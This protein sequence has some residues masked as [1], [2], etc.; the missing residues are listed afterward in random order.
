MRYLDKYK[1]VGDSCFTFFLLTPLALPNGSGDH[2]KTRIIGPQLPN[3][4]QGPRPPASASAKTTNISPIR[5]NGVKLKPKPHAKISNGN[6]TASVLVP[7]VLAPSLVPYTDQV[8]S[9]DDTSNT[10]VNSFLHMLSSL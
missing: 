1:C 4:S 6:G 2:G 8:D 9:D 3:T 10:Q 7:K 5:F